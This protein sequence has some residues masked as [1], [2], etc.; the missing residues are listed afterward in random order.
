[1]TGE[2]SS[3]LDGLV[4]R[5]LVTR[6]GAGYDRMRGQALEDLLAAG[7]AGH[8]AVVRRLGSTDYPRPL[9]RILPMFG[10]DESVA[11]LADVLYR[12]DIDSV[13]RTAAADALS[14]H[15]SAKAMDMLIEALE[16]TDMATVSAAAAGLADRGDANAVPFLIRRSQ[17]AT[18][19]PGDVDAS[20]LVAAAERLRQA[21]QDGHR[22]GI[23]F[24][25]DV[26]NLEPE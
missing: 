16:S 3:E 5:L 17:L 19:T 18:E 24:V 21:S 1:M 15:P 25:G 22:T 11:V 13:L 6:A 23:G 8:E 9:I 20:L 14:T 10:L 4:D 12:P 2:D 26:L 7:K